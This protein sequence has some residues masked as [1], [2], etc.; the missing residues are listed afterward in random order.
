MSDWSQWG[1]VVAVTNATVLVLAQRR[2]MVSL[3]DL[4][5]FISASS[6]PDISR[7][8]VIEFTII[9]HA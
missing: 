1:P 9:S 8:L 3:F 7:I 2:L 6:S 5:L 4:L